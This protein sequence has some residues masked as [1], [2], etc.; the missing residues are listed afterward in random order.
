M[1]CHNMKK[2][3]D[4]L[5]VIDKVIEDGKYKATWASLMNHKVPHWYQHAKFGIFIHWGVYSVPAFGEWYPRWMYKPHEQ[6]YGQYFYKYH[7]ENYGSLKDFGY[8]DFVPMFKAEKYN[9]AGWADLFK[10]AGAKFVMPVA[11]HHDGFQ[12]Y[13]SDLS[14]W[15]AT[16]KGPMRDCIGE[17]KEALEERNLV[18]TTSSHRAEHYWFSCG[19]RDLDSDIQ[20][21]IPYGHLYWPSY[22]E[23]YDTQADYNYVEELDKDFLDDWLARTCEIVDKYQPKIVY[24]D[25]WNQTT[26]FKPYMQKFAAYYYNRGIEWGKEV[27][28]NYK[29]DTMMQSTAV[30]DIE[31]GQLSDISPMFWQNDTSIATNSWCYN[32][33]NNYKKT[34]DIICDL[35]DVVS[36]NGSFL[37]NI[38]PKA[39]GTIPDK[40]VAI[41]KE[42]GKWLHLNGE[43]IYHSTYWK[44]YGEGPTKTVEGHFTD[45]LREPYTSEDFRFTFKDGVL[46]AFALTWPEDGCVRIKTLARNS[47]HYCGTIKDVEVLGA[48]DGCQFQLCSDYLSVWAKGIVTKNPVCI[49]IHIE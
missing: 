17:L 25:A 33:N 14:E 32:K 35:V 41:L 37:L 2:V 12:M 34:H 20:G 44:K 10:E 4:Y 40:E 15:C 39:D 27:T 29:F 24:F 11:E 31:R 48:P 46:Y 1:T 3:H 23:P 6:K 13:D 8:K 9:P 36:K 43:G 7:I 5:A 49:K 45:T 28:I 18:F 26:A 30:P 42:I 47:S 38:G 19:G 22:K 16:K 21:D